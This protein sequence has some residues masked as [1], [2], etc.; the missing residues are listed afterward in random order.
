MKDVIHH[1]TYHKFKLWDRIKILFGQ[2]LTVR[3]EIETEHEEVL[4]TGNNKCTTSVAVFFPRKAQ[5][6]GEMMPSSEKPE[7]AKT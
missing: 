5:G 6:G 4:F 3:S 1:N 7:S 2:E